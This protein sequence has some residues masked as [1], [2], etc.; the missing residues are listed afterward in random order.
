VISSADN[1]RDI[2]IL[3]TFKRLLV[4]SYILK[5][6]RLSLSTIVYLSNIT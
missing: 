6:Y 3:Y 1:L 4:K 2:S 5:F